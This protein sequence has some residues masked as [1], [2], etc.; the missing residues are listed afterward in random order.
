MNENLNILITN[1][2]GIHAPGIKYLWESAKD[3]GEIF[4]VAPSEE[5]S[6]SGMGM[7]LT[8]P[9][10]T[11]AI[12]WDDNT[13]AWSV[14][15]TP[16]DCVKLGCSV[17]LKNSPDL[18]I[19]GI[20]RGTNAGRNVLYSGTIGG[21]IEGC[22]RGIPGIAFSYDDLSNP[23][24]EKCIPYIQ[25]IIKFFLNVKMPKGTIINVNFPK[26]EIKGIKLAHQGK[27]YWIEE[28]DERFHPVIQTYY[29][30]GGK[31]L[32]FEES[33]ESDIALLKKGYVAVVP[34]HVDNMTDHNF[35]KDHQETFLKV[36]TSV[37]DL[38]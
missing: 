34:L 1:D 19:S 27:S 16:A 3:F 38:V 36:F 12:K 33:D 28:V 22:F 35:F 25:L 17:L 4:I 10:R 24:Y 8:S 20:N 6:G 23:E 11:K 32:S 14:T 5:K 29:W 2:D 18:I 21:V 31:P 13:K 26:G 37:T 30:M 9:L 7:T 15:G